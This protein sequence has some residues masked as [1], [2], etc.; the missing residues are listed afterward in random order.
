M[1]HL[2]RLILIACASF[3]L[4]PIAKADFKIC[5]R[6]P[7]SITVAAAWVSPSGGFVSEGWWTLRACGGCETVVLRS[8]TSDPHNYFFYAHAG[9]KEWRGDS[10]FCTT[11]SA[12]RI[13][14]AKRCPLKRRGE[15]KGFIHVTSG[16]GNQTRT[17]TGR[18]SSGG[19]CID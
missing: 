12:F 6:T 14:D 15:M 1:T 17:L 19:V 13:S 16:S 9:A 10:M 7:E 8:E 5:N 2:R 11:R 18:S 3:L 4:A